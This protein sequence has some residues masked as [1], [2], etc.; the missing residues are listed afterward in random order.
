MVQWNDDSTDNVSNTDQ[1]KKKK[2]GTPESKR[3]TRTTENKILTEVQ[4]TIIKTT[5]F[6]AKHRSFSE[7]PKYKKSYDIWS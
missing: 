2:K 1:T 5:T 7:N 6:A 3:N 4:T